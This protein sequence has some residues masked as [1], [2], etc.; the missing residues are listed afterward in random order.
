MARKKHYW[1]FKSEPEV[2]SIDDL[3]AD[4]DQTTL[5][6]GIRNY[7]ARNL[8][9][10]DIKAGDGVLFYHSR[11]QPIGVAGEAKVVRSAYPDPTQYDKKSKYY[12]AK[13]T[14]EVPRWF[15]VDI[16][17]VAAYQDVILLTDLKQHPDLSEMMVAQKGSRLSVQ[18]VTPA[19]WK[20][21]RSL[22]KKRR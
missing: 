12:D 17:F 21:V 22:A 6:D 18:P 16:Q 15:V 7:Q 9:R 11:T 20:T 5:W 2:Y 8:L 1:L 10:D 19:E 13:S 3:A 4:T 14:P